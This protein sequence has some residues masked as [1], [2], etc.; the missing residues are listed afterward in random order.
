MNN[1]CENINQNSPS[2]VTS[3]SSNDCNL[4]FKFNLWKCDLNQT[5]RIDTYNTYTQCTNS[6]KL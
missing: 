6:I 1:S 5:C 2:N 4:N 3:N